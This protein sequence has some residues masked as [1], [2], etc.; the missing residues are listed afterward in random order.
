MRLTDAER[1]A[2][3]LIREH[4]AGK[5]WSFTWDNSKTRGGWCTHGLK[6]IGLSRPLTQLREKDNVRDT[7]LHEIAHAMRGVPQTYGRRRI[8][9][10][11]WAWKSYALKLGARPE[12]CFD[13]AKIDGAWTGTCPGCGLTITRHRLTQAMRTRYGCRRCIM[14]HPWA[15]RKQFHFIWTKAETRTTRGQIAANRRRS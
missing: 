6:Q 2:K 11:D 9:H 12:R 7:I 10:H 3:A 13:D 1:M 4:L 8:N 5:G 14:S 15:D